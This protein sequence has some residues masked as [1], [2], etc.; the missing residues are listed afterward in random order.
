MSRA[1]GESTETRTDVVADQIRQRIVLGSYPPG[2]RLR[3]DRLASDLDVSRVPLREAFRELVAEGLVEVYP[4]RGA[5]V[6]PL[7][8]QELEDCFRLLETLEVMAAERTV[9]SGHADTAATMRTHLERLD[10]LEPDGDRVER[11][12]AHRAFHFTMFA[13]LG[14]G[15]MQRHVQMLWHTCE[16]YINLASTGRRNEE[17]RDEHRQLVRHCAAGD[18]SMVAAI[19]RVHVQHAKLAAMDRMSD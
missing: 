8:Q 14:G 11:L 15:T 4:H 18:A 17:A 13:A 7:H 16:R 2:T 10:T 5:V 1:K 9:R 3:L 6:S 19:A 12:R